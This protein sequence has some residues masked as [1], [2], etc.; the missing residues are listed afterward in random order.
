LGDKLE[1]IERHCAPL[2]PALRER[3]RRILE[4]RE[5]LEGA[6]MKPP[7]FSSKAPQVQ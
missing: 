7:S 1:T 4:N 6:G 5:G 2:V 3:V